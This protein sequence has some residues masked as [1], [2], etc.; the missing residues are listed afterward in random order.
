MD[1]VLRP[2]TLSRWMID[3]TDKY[4]VKVVKRMEV[5]MKNS[6]RLIHCDET[7]FV[8]LEDRKKEVRTKNS[9]SYMWVY[10]TAD[11]YGSPP[12]FIY[13][14]GNDK[15]LFTLAFPAPGQ[16]DICQQISNKFWSPPATSS[17]QNPCALIRLLLRKCRIYPPEAL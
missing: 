5:K 12:I 6:A 9:N 11:Q 2:Q 14:I 7:P 10:H 15:V 1:V 4:L 8:C 13:F 16:F 17:L 3:I